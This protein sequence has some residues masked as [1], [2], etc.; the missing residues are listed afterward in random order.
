VSEEEGV[1]ITSVQAA[2]P[3]AAGG[4]TNTE[5]FYYVE[6]FD[7]QNVVDLVLSV[8]NDQVASERMHVPLPMPGQELPDLVALAA[9]PLA[10]EVLD[11]QGLPVP[12]AEVHVDRGPGLDRYV[13]EVIVADDRGRFRVGRVFSD[14]HLRA[15]EESGWFL[16]A[17]SQ[18]VELP[19][20]DGWATVEPGVPFVSLILDEGGAG[21]GQ[22]LDA[23]TSG[24]VRDGWAVA[25]SA[26]E[27]LASG[28]ADGQGRYQLGL[29]PRWVG[30]RVRVTVAAPGFENWVR[31]VLVEARDRVHSLPEYLSP[32]LGSQLVKGRVFLRETPR[33]VAQVPPEAREAQ[34]GDPVE[35]V[36]VRAW[37]A[38]RGGPIGDW[39]LDD[40]LPEEF[41]LRWE[42]QTD[43][44]G[45]FE[46]L[47]TANQQ[48]RIVLVS[49]VPGAQGALLLG[50][51]GP[52]PL[53]SALAGV[54]FLQ[55]YGQQLKVDVGGLDAS[56]RFVVQQT[57][58]NP[59]TDSSWSGTVP[60]P[61]AAVGWESVTIRTA[62]EGS[63]FFDVRVD[64]GPV[65]A[66]VASTDGWLDVGELE[67]LVLEIPEFRSV[68]G[69]ILRFT[70]ADWPDL[71]L[72]FVGPAVP[73]WRSEWLGESDWCVRPSRNGEF[74]LSAIPPGDY[75]LMLYRPVGVEGVEILAERAVTVEGDLSQVE[76]WAERAAD[77]SYLQVLER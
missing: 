25:S 72:A 39:V 73:A 29:P 46:F 23:S 12:G 15:H 71:C 22:I 50:R 35:G 3:A 33:R 61:G 52:Q 55:S 60:L 21:A 17:R 26:G 57:S 40:G 75:R 62:K 20:R 66:P 63:A 44:E 36:T 67:P 69:E 34:Q 56:R 65:S 27:E 10:G 6:P 30:Q 7:D 41:T 37:I 9:V 43:A 32:G 59:W 42:G 70:A 53:S 16:G 14:Q 45:R 49:E 2:A 77:G 76:I 8:V 48:D 5:G 19:M 28:F 74:H 11:S 24:P 38:R 13:E 64:R 47:A 4:V 51:W 18:G 68:Q 54:D 31:D 58:W 1:R